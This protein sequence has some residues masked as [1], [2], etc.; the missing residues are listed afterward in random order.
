MRQ[1]FVLLSFEKSVKLV[2][3]SGKEAERN[4]VL[5]NCCIVCHTLYFHDGY[6]TS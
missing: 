5:G 6:W 1:W 4:T 2:S 3:R